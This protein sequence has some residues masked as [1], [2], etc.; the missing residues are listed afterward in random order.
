[1]WTQLQ[2][3]IAPVCISDC[4]C[5]WAY[6]KVIYS[7]YRYNSWLCNPLEWTW[8]THYHHWRGLRIALEPNVK[9]ERTLSNKRGIAGLRALK[10][11]K[12]QDQQRGLLYQWNTDNLRAPEHFPTKD[13][14]SQGRKVACGHW[15]VVGGWY[16]EGETHWQPATCGVHISISAIS[17]TN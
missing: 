5:C 6:N 1:M 9:C 15:A 16:Y 3:G 13:R 4:W 14:A 11:L 2:E 8:S 7:Y 17:K 10:D 12:E